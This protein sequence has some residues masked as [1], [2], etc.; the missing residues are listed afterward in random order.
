M[1]ALPSVLRDDLA[2][3]PKSLRG[4]VRRQAS[5]CVRAGCRLGE[6]QQLHALVARFDVDRDFRQQRHAI[7]VRHHLHHRRQRG[8]AEPAGA[9]RRVVA[10]NASAWSRRQWPSSSRISRR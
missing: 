3:R 4:E 9:S 7:A 5:R 8:G 2:Q 1:Y 10:Q 6:A